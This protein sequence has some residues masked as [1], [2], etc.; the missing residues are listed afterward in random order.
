MASIFAMFV[1]TYI[2]SYS[3]L[4]IYLKSIFILCISILPVLF[5]NQGS[6]M[7]L[8]WASVIFITIVISAIRN[9]SKKHYLILAIIL[10]VAVYIFYKWVWGSIMFGFIKLDLSSFFTNLNKF[11]ELSF[12]RNWLG[13]I[14]T[15]ILILSS[16]ISWKYISKFDKMLLVASALLF[17]I[18]T[19][20]SASIMGQG[21]TGHN[22]ANRYFTFSH[23]IQL[24]MF[25]SLLSGVYKFIVNNINFRLKKEVIFILLSIPLISGIYSFTELSPSIYNFSILPQIRKSVVEK[26]KAHIKYID[27][28]VITSN[29]QSTKSAFPNRNVYSANLLKENQFIDTLKAQY[30][31]FYYVPESMMQ[32]S[33]R[34]LLRNKGYVIDEMF[35]VNCDSIR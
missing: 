3:K 19:L 12:P 31:L 1:N 5:H 29:T 17:I 20:A 32:D 14:V 27:Y 15:I 11:I 34:Q 28:A 23:S 10:V 4:N 2:L 16:I 18:S 9:N 13:I 8:F 30:I 35:V 7:L 24:I 25:A 6:F 21:Y 33:L 22:G 26:Q